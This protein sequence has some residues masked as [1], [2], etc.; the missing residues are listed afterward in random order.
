MEKALT[1]IIIL[2]YNVGRLVEDCIESILKSDCGDVEIILVDNASKDDSQQRC[3]KRF[4]QI[5]LIQNEENLGYCEGNNVGIRSAQGEFVVILNPDTTVDNQWLVELKKA[6]NENGDGLYQPKLLAM[7]DTKR[8]NTAGNMIQVFGFGYSKAKGKID[9]GKF[10][11]FAEVNYASGACLFTS[12]DTINKIGLFDPFLFAYHDDLDLGW[13]GALLGI[14]SYYVPKSVVY[15]A[16]SFSFKWSKLKFYLLERNR[17]YCILTN[18]SRSTFYKMLPGLIAIEVMMFFYY[19][20]RGM[21]KEKISGYYSLSKN[22]KLIKQR[23][24][25][26]QETRIIQ[27]KEIINRFQNKMEAPSEVA[28]SFQTKIFNNILEGLSK[29]LRS[30]L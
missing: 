22:R 14:R 21:V 18:Y 16:E 7:Q 19:L 27:D 5:K 4:P 25:K 10:D 23:Y 11:K 29:M 1:S 8:I 13:R 9:D 28:N 24:K 30:V 20:G 3:K 26:I 2:N 12:R 15:H 6:H 17:W